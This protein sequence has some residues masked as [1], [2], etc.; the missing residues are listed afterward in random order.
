MAGPPSQKS[1]SAHLIA[2]QPRE[3]WLAKIAAMTPAEMEELAHDW[4]F[5]ARGEQKPPPGDWR[6]WLYLA[7]RG[8]G[9]T[10]SG[11]EWVRAQLPPGVV[12]S[13][14]GTAAAGCLLWTLLPTQQSARHSAT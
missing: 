12:A 8:S 4:L 5:W 6:V 10:R 14:G 11:A 9:K 3:Q 13:I 1:S 2:S 7:G